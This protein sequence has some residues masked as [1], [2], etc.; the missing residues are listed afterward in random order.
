MGSRCCQQ[1]CICKQTMIHQNSMVSLDSAR[2]A[3]SFVQYC[4]N[5][6]RNMYGL[7]QQLQPMIS[8]NWKNFSHTLSIS[9]LFRWYFS[10]S[11]HYVGNRFLITLLLYELETLLKDAGRVRFHQGW[12]NKQIIVYFE[13]VCLARGFNWRHFSP[14]FH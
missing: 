1:T 9:A 12:K 5:Q 2:Y 13:Q 7:S 10:I 11:K 14:W 8:H 6:R 3:V 4:S